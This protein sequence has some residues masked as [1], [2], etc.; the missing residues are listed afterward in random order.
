VYTLT[1]F[2]SSNNC[3]DFD[4]VYV[5]QNI[6]PPPANAGAP[7]VLTCY[8]PS[9]ALTGSV[10]APGNYTY[11]W[12]ASN[13]GAITGGANTLTP[14]INQAGTYT[15]TVRNTANGCSSVVQTT[16]TTNQT[17]PIALIANPQTLTCAVVQTTLNANASSTGNMDY[18]WI[19]Q[20]GNFLDLSNPR[21]PVI[22][23]PGIY[24][25]LLTNLDN[26]CTA[27]AAVQVNQNIQLPNAEAG[28][29]VLLTCAN[30]SLQ[31]NGAGSSAGSNFTYTWSGPGILSGANTLT[32]TVNAAGAYTLTVLNQSNDCVSSD[33]VQVN[34]DTLA[35][36]LAL[37]QPGL[38]TCKTPAVTLD[39]NGSQSGTNIAYAWS[40]VNGILQ[41]I[42]NAITATAAAPGQY[43][44]LV[45]NTSNGC[46][47]AGFV[48]VGQDI[49][50]P[51]AEAGPTFLL[52]C[53]DN[54]ATLQ[55]SGSTG[56]NYSYAWNTANGRIVSGATTLNPVVDEPGLYTLVVTNQTNGCTR[57][58]G[59]TITRE[60]NVPT[61][62]TF[63]LDPPSCQD[64]DGLI[65][66]TAVTGGYG[67][68]FY[69]IDGGDTFHPE[70]DF[71][72]IAPGPY[73]LRIQDA[74]GCEFQKQL[75]VPQAPDPQITIVP[76]IQLSLGD[77]TVLNAQLPAGYPLNLIDT[78]IWEPMDG[79]HFSGN[80]L[81][82][83]LRPGVRPFRSIE[84]KVTLISGEG[85]QAE[86]RVIV[87]VDREP[88]IY[89]PNAF[90]PW[91][92]DGE[93]DRV[94]IF[95]D[96]DQ[97]LEIKSFRVFDRWGSMVFEDYNFQ[98]N[99]PSHGWDGTNNGKYLT[100]AV[101]VYT[102]E[103]LMIDGRIILLKGDITIVR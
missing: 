58:D 34:I 27:S 69:S 25:L 47:R 61:N 55:G 12:A 53:S 78:I 80:D 26:G 90:S 5:P 66:F 49:Q 79:L 94:L 20:G 71:E 28:A 10:A 70:L 7:V 33:I 68:Y 89:V 101:F 76:E 63:D 52:T 81:L 77:S 85:C 6:T 98:P 92:S 39:G 42:A 54:E 84:Y 44:L 45:T 35:P 4:T 18:D 46:T 64:N 97:V 38:I 65:S 72:N 1:V 48:T 29:A 74:N 103:V 37:A 11:Q 86:D 15:L 95:A 8:N 2:D 51:N 13:G 23:A 40:T 75:V 17:P 14:T 50:Q 67:P 30:P 3:S 59:V 32:P 82:S 99:D 96:G 22:N 87:R 21:L 62:F 19:T 41:G 60:A 102:A 91:D 31:L 88:K 24:Q 56:S 36:I 83:L 100:P 57:A 16:A 93:N 9:L 43:R 73:T